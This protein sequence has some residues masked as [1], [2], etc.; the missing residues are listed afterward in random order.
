MKDNVFCY[1]EGYAS[2]FNVV[3]QAGDIIKPGAFRETLKTCGQLPVLWQ[4]AASCVLGYV[5]DIKEDS[6][7]LWVRLAI[8]CETLMGK[9][10]CALLNCGV[11]NGLSIGFKAI[12]AGKQAKHRVLHEVVLKEVSVVTFAANNSA[13]ITLVEMPP[14]LTEVASS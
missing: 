11:L 2:V 9:D 10:V 4:H 1:V 13:K 12:R 14:L 6:V 3:D 5:C 8:C 7:G